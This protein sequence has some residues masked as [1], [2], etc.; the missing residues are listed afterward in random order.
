MNDKLHQEGDLP[1]YIDMGKHMNVIKYWLRYG[2]FYRINGKPI[3]EHYYH[4]KFWIKKQ[5]MYNSTPYDIISIVKSIN[6]DEINYTKFNDVYYC[7]YHNEIYELIQNV[8]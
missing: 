4:G 6:N 1:A 2:K 7:Y 5:I 3:I 8:P